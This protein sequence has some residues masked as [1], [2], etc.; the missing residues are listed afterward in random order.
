[1]K[2]LRSEVKTQIA[3]E[4][5]QQD[6]QH[7]TDQDQV[8]HALTDDGAIAS[9]SQIHR[10]ACICGC[11]KAPGGFCAVCRGLV[12]VVCFGLCDHC[13]MPLCGRHSVFAQCQE[14]GF[15]RLCQSCARS[16]RAR[17][18][19]VRIVKAILSPLIRFE[20]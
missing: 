20:D 9:Q 12:C 11:L 19:S 14:D 1:M 18:R 8:S 16:Q 2:P 4:P 5:W 13:R 3:H 6:R 17:R 7:A 10:Q 15:V